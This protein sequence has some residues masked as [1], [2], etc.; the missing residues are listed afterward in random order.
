MDAGAKALIENL[1]LESS[2]FEQYVAAVIEPGPLI[3]PPS[4]TTNPAVKRYSTH[5]PIV[6]DTAAV[7][8]VR[9]DGTQLRH[10]TLGAIRNNETWS[11]ASIS[12]TDS[13]WKSMP[14]IAHVKVHPISLFDHVHVDSYLFQ[15][16]TTPHHADY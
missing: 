7:E 9:P 8:W 12:T 11:K 2:K 14:Y 5:Y 13:S 3:P 6:G 15:Y 1:S 16:M 4:A 10:M